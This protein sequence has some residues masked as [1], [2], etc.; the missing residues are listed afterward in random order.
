MI[1]NKSSLI[2]LHVN[3]TSTKR[4]ETHAQ[5]VNRLKREEMGQE[6]DIHG[7]VAFG[8]DGREVSTALGRP[9][10]IDGE[11]GHDE[12]EVSE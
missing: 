6:R 9:R 12:Q 3:F 11:K 10:A 2:A 7:G 8:E 1:R 4:Q 5:S